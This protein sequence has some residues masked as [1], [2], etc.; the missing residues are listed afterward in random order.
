MHS[1]EV[2][3]YSRFRP[4]YP[5]EIYDFL[6]FNKD[7]PLHLLDLGCGT[8]F[9]VQSFLDVFP[10]TA[11]T[12]VDENLDLLNFSKK[13]LSTHFP[14]HSLEF[15]H[16]SIG[17]ETL[18]ALPSAS[19]QVIQIAS[20]WH[21]F[22][23]NISEENLSHLL[24]SEG[25]LY[26]H[27]YQFP[28]T[29]TPHALNEWI[30]QGFN[31][32]WKPQNQTPRGSLRDLTDRFRHLKDFREIPVPKIQMRLKMNSDELSNHLFSQSR[33]LK[34]EENLPAQSRQK[35]RERLTQEISVQFPSDGKTE[36]ALEFDFNWKGVLFQKRS[37]G[38]SAR[39]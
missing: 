13:H 4:L 14:N 32:T 21:W 39:G 26:I 31:S 35:E 6:P 28:K 27:E 16:H 17:D 1:F 12:A 18:R 8:G 10:Q 11:V 15:L 24:Q 25:L 34:F 38:E 29:V 30:R 3:S 19:F 36:G 20:A 7:A 23:R 2:D 9:S 5:R 37:A 22:H 33:Y